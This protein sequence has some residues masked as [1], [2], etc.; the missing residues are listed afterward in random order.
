MIITTDLCVSHEELIKIFLKA[1]ILEDVVVQHVDW[2]VRGR[3]HRVLELRTDNEETGLQFTFMGVKHSGILNMFDDYLLKCGVGQTEL[4]P[5]T[6][7][8]Q[9][10]EE[11]EAEQTRKFMEEMKT[12]NAKFI[13][14][15]DEHPNK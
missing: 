13:K 14:R 1:N 11:K 3:T 2:E 12:M 6:W 5:K 15:L 10:Q 8:R 4:K 7:H 9:L